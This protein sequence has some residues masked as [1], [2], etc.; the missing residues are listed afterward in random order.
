MPDIIYVDRS[1]EDQFILIGCDGIWEKYGD[2]HIELTKQFR[3]DLKKDHALNC[4]KNFFDKNLSVTM[5]SGPYGK[6]NM[7]ALIIE[8][9]KQK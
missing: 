2:D 6:D 4:L 9:K 5:Q 8:L 3:G 7:T 1:E